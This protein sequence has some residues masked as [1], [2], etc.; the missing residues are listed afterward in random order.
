MGDREV[1]APRPRPAAERGAAPRER[2]RPCE[3]VEAPPWRAERLVLEPEALE[4]ALG[5]PV[6]AGGDLDLV[7]ALAKQRDHRPQHDRMGRG[8]AVD[9]DPHTVAAESCG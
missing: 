6:V 5:L 7:P 9:P 8:G 4:Q 2:P 3:A 1:E